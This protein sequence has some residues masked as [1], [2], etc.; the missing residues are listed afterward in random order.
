LARAGAI[1]T[2]FDVND[3]IDPA[4]LE[5]LAFSEPFGRETAIASTQPRISA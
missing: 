3:W 1:P 4:P 5:R 2:A